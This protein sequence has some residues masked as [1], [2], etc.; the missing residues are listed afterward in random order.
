MHSTQF[1]NIF[2]VIISKVNCFEK[3]T[4]MSKDN[5]NIFNYNIQYHELED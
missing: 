4:R 3:W 2:E 5:I 1:S